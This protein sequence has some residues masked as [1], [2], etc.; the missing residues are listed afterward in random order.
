MLLGELP[1]L[2]EIQS[3]KDLIRSGLIWVIRAGTINAL[4]ETLRKAPAAA[5]LGDQSSSL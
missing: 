1:E 3:A 2:E 5:V 4:I